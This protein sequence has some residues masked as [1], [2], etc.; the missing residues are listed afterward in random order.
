MSKD[1]FDDAPDLTPAEV[2]TYEAPAL[3]DHGTLEE[4]TATGG[5]A[6]LPADLGTT[7]S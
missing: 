2:P 6:P 4:L 1:V 5:G 7:S 3:T